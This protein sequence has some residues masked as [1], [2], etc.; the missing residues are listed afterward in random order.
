MK[1]KTHPESKPQ[2]F[3][4][5]K[6]VMCCTSAHP[7]DC[8]RFLYQFVCI[9]SQAAANDRRPW[10]AWWQAQQPDKPK[11]LNSIRFFSWTNSGHNISEHIQ[12]KWEHHPTQDAKTQMLAPLAAC[13]FDI[14]ICSTNNDYNAPA[15]TDSSSSSSS[16]SSLRRTERAWLPPHHGS[17]AQYNAQY[18]NHE[19][20]KLATWKQGV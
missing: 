2:T 4:G 20:R 13:H 11:R 10:M 12:I 5:P 6:R 7:N 8:I 14:Q 9:A 15:M 1:T 17:I 3:H 18:H 16:S 19:K